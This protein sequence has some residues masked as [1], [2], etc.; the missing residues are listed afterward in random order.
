MRIAI[1]FTDVLHSGYFSTD[2]IPFSNGELMCIGIVHRNHRKLITY[3]DYIQIKTIY[4]FFCLFFPQND[5]IEDATLELKW[6]Y[7]P[8]QE[9]R[10][11]NIFIVKC[12][13][14]IL[15]TVGGVRGLNMLTCS[16]VSI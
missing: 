10:L 12:Q 3:S 1:S 7:L 2:R 13:N 6:Y 11:H 15:L 16:D 5:R 9:Q 8:V 14:P 4:T